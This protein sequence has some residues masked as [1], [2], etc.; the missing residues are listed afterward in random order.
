MTATIVLLILQKSEPS[1]FIEPK[2][3]KSNPQS[4]SESPIIWFDFFSKGNNV[5]KFY[6]KCTNKAESIF[7]PKKIKRA[8][9]VKIDSRATIINNPCRSMNQ[10][11]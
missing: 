4:S 6:N 1:E 3:E 10:L 8:K 11:C 5:T 7:T 9:N 2:V